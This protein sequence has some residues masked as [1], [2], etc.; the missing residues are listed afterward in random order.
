MT[1]SYNTQQKSFEGLEYR[2]R[3]DFLGK[4]FMFLKIKG[5]YF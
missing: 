5:D 4:K 2:D 1:I 3:I